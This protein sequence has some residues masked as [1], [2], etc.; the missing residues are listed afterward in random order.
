MKKLIIILALF[1][2]ESA[3]AQKLFTIQNWSDS[4][5]FRWSHPTIR[6]YSTLSDSLA[7]AVPGKAEFY[8]HDGSYYAVNS[9]ADYYNWFT[10]AYWYR[11]NRP[12]VEYETFYLLGDNF[13]MV[14]WLLNQYNSKEYPDLMTVE[15]PFNR[16]V[17]AF[18]SLYFDKR[19]LRK[20]SNERAR[21]LK[22]NNFASAGKSDTVFGSFAGSTSSSSASGG[23]SSVSSGETN[24]SR[25]I[26][27]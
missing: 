3:S 27:N 4:T 25:S 1:V 16:R 8:Y 15:D 7:Q 5:T 14:D 23:S 21:M 20:L 6:G 11:F 2:V 26:G 17:V 18:N 12:V 22:K 19:E 9:W 24:A 13:M 10:K